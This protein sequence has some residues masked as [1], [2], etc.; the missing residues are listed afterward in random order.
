MITLLKRQFI[1]NVALR[2]AWNHLARFEGWPS[3][4]AHI[5]KIELQPPGALGPESS[6]VIHLSRWLK[7]KFQMT[8]FSLLQ[9]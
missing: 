8:E 5:K 6:G 2:S 3:W 9:N 4:A 1:V 7:P